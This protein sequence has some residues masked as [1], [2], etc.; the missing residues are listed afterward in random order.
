VDFV[1]NYQRPVGISSPNCDLNNWLSHL[2]WLRV[3]EQ[4]PSAGEA[5]D[6]I[7]LVTQLAND[8]LAFVALLPE[9][10]REWFM[11]AA[12]AVKRGLEILDR[13]SRNA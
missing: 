1:P 8:F 2:T 5:W 12:E 3:E 4:A 7:P 11:D 6:N 9:E 13:Q 10:R